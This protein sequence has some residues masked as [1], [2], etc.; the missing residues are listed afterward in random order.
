MR[1][2][3]N[4]IY[5]AIFNPNTVN[6]G[7]VFPTLAAGV[8]VTSGKSRAFGA[9]AQVVAGATVVANSWI[10]GVVMDVFYFAGGEGYQVGLGSGAGGAEVLQTGSQFYHGFTEATAAGELNYLTFSYAPWP[11]FWPSATRIAAESAATS[12]NARVVGVSVMYRTGIGT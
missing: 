10:T 1:S 12:A 9:W 7:G 4:L 6:T 2:F 11:L 8:A 3:V 5:N